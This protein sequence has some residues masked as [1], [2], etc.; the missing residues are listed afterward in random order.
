MTY[1][2]TASGRLPRTHTYDRRVTLIANNSFG[3][4]RLA[5]NANTV[6][7]RMYFG[8]TNRQRV[9]MMRRRGGAR[10]SALVGQ[11]CSVADPIVDTRGRNIMLVTHVTR[12]EVLVTEHVVALQAAIL[13]APEVLEAFI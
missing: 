2:I 11:G 13:V 4:F 10:G 9:T 12:D 5:V 7:N 3:K 1:S 6:G 8:L